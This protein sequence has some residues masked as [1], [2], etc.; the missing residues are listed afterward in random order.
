MH[1]KAGGEQIVLVAVPGGFEA[2]SYDQLGHLQFWQQR[3]RLD[4]LDAGR[5]EQLSL[6]SG[7][8]AAARAASAARILAGMQ[9]ATFIVYGVFTG[10]GSG[11]A[12]AF[13]TGARRLGCDQGRAERQHRPVGRAGRS[14]SHR[15]VVQLRLRGGHLITEDCPTNRPLS[16]CGA[17]PIVKRWS[18]TGSDF[19]LS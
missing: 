3:R 11:N 8:R 16:Q 4:D 7:A 10:D 15:A 6:R 17:H 2:A 12:V 1:T 9:H 13:T 19:A 5:G 14:G 18:W